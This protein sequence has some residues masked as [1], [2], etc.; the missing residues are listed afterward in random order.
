M[1]LLVLL[2]QAAQGDE[3]RAED[4]RYGGRQDHVE[5]QR[6]RTTRRYATGLNRKEVSESVSEKVSRY[7]I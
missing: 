4:Q 5:P 7:V 1:R 3:N 2:A 6:E